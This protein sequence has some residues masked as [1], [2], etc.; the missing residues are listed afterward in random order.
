M[1]TIHNTLFRS[2]ELRLFQCKSQPVHYLLARRSYATANSSNS[3]KPTA[4]HRQVTT[5]NDDGRVRWSELS[6]REKAAR[7]TQQSFNFLVIIAGV[8]MTGAVAT[9]MYK[10]VFSTDS[11]TSH[12][13]RTVTRIKKD[14]TCID[15]LAGGDPRKIKAYG[16]PSWNRWSR[17]RALAST[18]HKDGVG[19]EHMRMHFNVEGPMARG[20]VQLH[21]VKRPGQSEWDYQ[22][23][24]VDVPGHQRIFL[25]DADAGKLADR[26]DGKMFGLKWW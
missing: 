22:L 12:F 13:N 6:V 5:F 8:V 10:E 21:M 25:E 7:S 9:L 14:T 16:E 17:N 4:S 2:A 23:L 20:V 11:K 24:A 1:A 18:V 15:I 3:S 19:V 26:K